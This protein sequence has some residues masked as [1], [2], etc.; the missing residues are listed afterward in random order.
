VREVNAFATGG[1]APD[2]TILLRIDPR[3]GLERTAGRGDTDRLER[4]GGDF[5][6]AVGAAY[7]ALAAASPERIAVVD[8]AAAPEDVLAAALAALQPLL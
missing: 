4:A 2:R 7:D 3:A 5:F 8:A 1:L 6:A